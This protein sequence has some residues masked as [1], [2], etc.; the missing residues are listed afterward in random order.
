[1]SAGRS[2]ATVVITVIIV[3]VI[4]VSC[5]KEEG[6]AGDGE[7]EGAGAVEERKIIRPPQKAAEAAQ[8]NQAQRSSCKNATQSQG[9]KK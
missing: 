9:N 8:K 5:H 2:Y 3:E 4:I 1:M 6:G 7:G